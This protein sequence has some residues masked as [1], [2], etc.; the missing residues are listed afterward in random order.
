MMKVMGAM[1]A[2][3]GKNLLY[4]IISAKDPLNP[5]K[6]LG[7]I[8]K[9]TPADIYFASKDAKK[10]LEKLRENYPQT[11]KNRFD[12]ISSFTMETV[13][14]LVTFNQEIYFPLVH[15]KRLEVM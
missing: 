5:G 13:T 7:N 11:K 15:L 9:W 3:S 14:D 10:V 12:R 2:L 6:Y 1:S 4:I 8:N